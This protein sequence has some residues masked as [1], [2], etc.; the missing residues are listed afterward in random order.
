MWEV[1][2]Q[3]TGG[4]VNNQREKYQFGFD[5]IIGP[6]AKQDEVFER[7]ASRSV[8]GSLE[9]FNGTVFAYGQTGSGKTFT[10]SGGHDRYVDRGIIP[11]AISRLYGEISKRHDASYSVQI[12]YVEIYND[13]GYDL[14]DPDHETTALEDLP[15]VQLLE[16]DE[17]NV[18][19]R[20][21]ST[22]RADNEEEA[23]NLLFLGD[24]NKAITETVSYT[25]LTLPT[26]LRV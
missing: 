4:Y 13:Q 21:V 5:G 24:T 19:M 26:I 20:N 9:G 11:R 25:H 23:L 6:E 3:E 18:T 17:G 1:P 2:K 22:H 15:K 8:L 14:L 12:T 16:D 10:I 7:V